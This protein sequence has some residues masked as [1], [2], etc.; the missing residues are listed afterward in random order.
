MGD[1]MKLI[2]EVQSGLEFSREKVIELHMDF[3]RNYCCHVCK[4]SLNW[5]N[6][7]EL[8]VALIA[9]N[10][11]LDKFQGSEL[12]HFRGFA[13]LIIRSRL[14]D[15]FRKESRHSNKVV[16][17]SP[18]DKGTLPGEEEVSINNYVRSLEISDRVYEI[19]LF[20]EKLKEFGITFYDLADKSPTHTQTRDKL[21]D[22]ALFISREQELKN[23]ILGGKQLPIKLLLNK[24]ELSKKILETWRRYI[25]ALVILLTDGEL[26]VLR[27]YV[28]GGVK[29]D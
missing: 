16:F 11:A 12:T 2:E 1:G 15:Y 23:K 14:T 8:S 4:K 3:I 13:R 25:I 29:N 28:F 5:E 6:D 22:L 18:N 24:Y 19:N 26:P 7:D 20:N 9:F 17:L 27:E 21:K 10:E